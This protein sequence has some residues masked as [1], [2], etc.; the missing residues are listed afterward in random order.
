MRLHAAALFI[1]ADDVELKRTLLPSANA[2]IENTVAFAVLWRYQIVNASASH[3]IG[4]H[5]ADHL[6]T[7]LV[8]HE[9]SAIGSDQL[10][11]LGSHLDD[12]SEALLA[13]PQNI[14]GARAV[15]NVDQHIYGAGQA[16][17]FIEKRSWIRRECPAHSVRPL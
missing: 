15:R 5:R 12:S 9:K 17:F 11:A 3:L 8:H 4:R 13:F 1:Q 6:Q 14:L 16:P 2:L 7:R 10:H